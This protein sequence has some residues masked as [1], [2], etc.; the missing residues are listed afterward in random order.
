VSVTPAASAI[1]ADFLATSNNLRFL[2]DP[3]RNSVIVSPAAVSF[4]LC[5]FGSSDSVCSSSGLGFAVGPGALNICSALRGMDCEIAEK[6]AFCLETGFS[7]MFDWC[8]LISFCNFDT[9]AVPSARGSWFS[10]PRDMVTPSLKAPLELGRL[11]SGAKA[12]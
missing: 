8:S 3:I 1:G 2:R 10:F 4:V 5:P 11:N 12:G 9:E 7:A 6:P